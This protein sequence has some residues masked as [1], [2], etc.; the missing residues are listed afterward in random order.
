MGTQK[1]EQATATD[2]GPNGL[3]CAQG[4]PCVLLKAHDL[5]NNSFVDGYDQVA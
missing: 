2:G 5:T 4:M 3:L 1:A